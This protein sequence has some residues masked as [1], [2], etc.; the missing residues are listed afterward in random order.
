MEAEVHLPPIT[1]ETVLLRL[2][3]MQVQTYNIIQSTIVVNAVDSER[4]DEDYI[5][6]PNV[7]LFSEIIGQFTDSMTEC[8]ISASHV[9]KSITVSEK[10]RPHTLTLSPI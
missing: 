3:P 1:K 7:R 2:A 10:H 4:K 5:F 6:H 8:E 9:Y